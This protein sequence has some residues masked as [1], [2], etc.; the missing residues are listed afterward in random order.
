MATTASSTAL[1]P[2]VA[3]NQP[4]L[5]APDF[6]RKG[7]TTNRSSTAAM[8]ATP[9]ST[10]TSAASS[11]SFHTTKVRYEPMTPTMTRSPWARLNTR[12][13]LNTTVYPMP[14]RP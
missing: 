11:G 3:M 12:V 5:A 4:K 6:L 13:A 10:I 2:S 14:T 1:K 7:R 8:A 9:T